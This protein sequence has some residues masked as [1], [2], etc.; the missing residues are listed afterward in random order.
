MTVALITLGCPKNIV[1]GEHM[2]GILREQGLILTTDLAHADCAVVHTC[3]FIGDARDESVRMIRSLV[4]LKK[5]G[6]LKKVIVTGCYV[7]DEGKKIAEMFP[8]VDGFMGT[9]MLSSLGSFVT[10]GG[11]F[12]SGSAGGLLAPSTPRLLSS[13]LPSA[14]LRIAE[15]CNHR[16]SFCSIPRLRGR[17]VSRSLTD[18]VNEARHLADAGIR[19][20]VLVA[21]DITAY[22]RDRSG[23]LMLPQL[24][25]KIARINDI[26]WIRL[27]YAYPSTVSDEL[28]DS[29]KDE[30]KMCRYLDVPLQHA[31]RDV[32]RR[33]KR[34][35][36]VRPLLERLKKHVPDIAV[37]TTFIVG[38]PGETNEDFNQLRT[39]VSEGW[40][41]HLG[42][43]A[44]SDHPRTM[45]ARFLDKVPESIALK[46]QKEL[47]RVQKKIVHQ[48][49]A[50][51]IGS[52]E[53]ILVERQ[54]Q[55]RYNTKSSLIVGRARFQAPEIDSTVIVAGVVTPGTFVRVKITGFN[56]YD[57]IGTLV[58]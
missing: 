52:F 26:A 5:T 13:T 19:E 18:I 49:N 34:P 7:Q 36:Q 27:L 10:D 1:E 32:L 23:H 48:H 54:I 58:P 44:Y 40:F 4:K 9:G 24:L 46:R 33:M 15:G 56:G 38:F 20:L 45:S 14:Y 22:G 43:F 16:C 53:E 12:C 30:E 3:S 41:E 6:H 17:Y 29:I 39:L 57:L 55:K 51:R 42:A 28:I 47:M 50:A 37:R 31:S 11:G 2:A 25:K 35:Q 8:G 21:Q